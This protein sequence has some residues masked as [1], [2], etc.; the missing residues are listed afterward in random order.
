MFKEI[1]LKGMLE[2]IDTPFV[3]SI[4]PAKSPLAK[5]TGIFRAFNKGESV[6]SNKSN[7]FELLRIEIITLNRTTKPPII[8]TVFIE[9]IILAPRIAPKLLKSGGNFL[10]SLLLE[11]LYLFSVLFL[12]TF[13]N[14]KITPTVK[15]ERRCVKN[16]KNPIV[17]FPKREI[18]NSTNNK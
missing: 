14:L 16:S 4:I 8:R 15:E 11:L 3:S 18:P 6:N 13:Q 17:V 5:E 9:L 7:N 2:I 10:L 1:A 12:L